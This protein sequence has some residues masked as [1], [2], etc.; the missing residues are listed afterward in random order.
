M[1]FRVKQRQTHRERDNFWKA[2]LKCLIAFKSKDLGEPSASHIT[3]SRIVDNAQ[4]FLCTETVCIV[5][6]EPETH[7]TL[8]FSERNQKK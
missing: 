6:S 3:W 7:S 5:A 8:L 2:A 4:Y 1:S